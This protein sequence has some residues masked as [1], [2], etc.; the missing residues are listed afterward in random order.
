MKICAVIPVYNN[1]ATVGD[2]VTRARA[3]LEPDVLVVADGTTDGSDERA[4]EAGAP[5]I[6]H[7]RNLGKGRAI[8]TGLEEARK[9]GFT[10]AVV[11]DADG[12]H[13][14]ENIPRLV[15]AAWAFPDRIIVGTRRMDENNSPVTSRRGRSISN[16]WATLDGWQRCRDTQS[17]F[18]LYPVEQTMQLGCREPGFAFEMEVL[19]RAGW[20]GLRLQHVE[21]DVL[22]D[23]PGRVSHFDTCADNLR[24]TW[25]SF[26]MFWGMVLRLPLLL[27]RAFQRL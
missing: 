20:A 18:R 1:A 13:L 27:W 3:V 7:P 10:H 19:V 22:Y 2:V 24:F 14:P 4:R 8:L 15:E 25:L 23:W 6:T 17:G 16:F 26:R 5:V 12:Q 11:L 21:V 9:R